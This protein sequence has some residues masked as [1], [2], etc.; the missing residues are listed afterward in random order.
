MTQKNLMSNN[1]LVE[2]NWVYSVP[3]SDY[4]I[5]YFQHFYTHFILNREKTDWL[6]VFCLIVIPNNIFFYHK[7]I[8][9]SG[10]A[11]ISHHILWYYM[12]PVLRHFDQKSNTILSL[13]LFKVWVALQ[14]VVWIWKESYFENTLQYYHSLQ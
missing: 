5:A 11:L 10:S 2:Y 3:I 12:S 13:F 4:K 7:T 9:F 6:F 1:L 14:S 8:Q